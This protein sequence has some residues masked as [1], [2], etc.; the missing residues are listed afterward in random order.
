MLFLL[1]PVHRA[2]PSPNNQH[3]IYSC[4]NP[5]WGSKIQPV[6]IRACQLILAAVAICQSL[7]H[8]KLSY[9][10]SCLAY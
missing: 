8:T 6:S 3:L 1:R 7:L 9:M 5:Q 2:I 10:L 4:S